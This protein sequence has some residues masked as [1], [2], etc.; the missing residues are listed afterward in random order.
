MVTSSAAGPCGSRVHVESGIDLIDE[1]G[2]GRFYES[3]PPLWASVHTAGGFVAGAIGDTSLQ[4]WKQMH[5]INALTCFLCCR[6]AVRRIRDPGS[7]ERIKLMSA[8]ALIAAAGL[9][10]YSASKAAVASLTVGL[11]EE[12][13]AEKIWVNAVIPSIIDTPKPNRQ[14]MPNADH[15]KWP[16]LSEVAATIAFLASPQNE[17]TRGALVP[18]YGRS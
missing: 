15:D 4:M 18:V 9:S 6:E 7:V 5:D 10:A 13:A 2:V 16:K 11:S 12:L 14:A 3:L 1:A 17:V 8:A